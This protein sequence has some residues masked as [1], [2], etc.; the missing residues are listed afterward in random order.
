MEKELT[1]AFTGHR[2][3]SYRFHPD[4]AS[5][6]ILMTT[7]IGA[8][9]GNGV[10]TFLT[11][12]AAG[13]DIWGAELVLRFKKEYPDIRLIAVLPCESQADKWSVEL[14]ERY[15]NI[16]AECDETVYISRHYTKDCMFRRNR[17]LIDHAS[18]V[19]AIDNGSPRGG[20]A[21]T[22]NYA[23]QKHRAVITINPDT[24]SI[25]PYTIVIDERN[26]DAEKNS[27]NT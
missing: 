25:T 18:F 7:Q 6:K 4:C 5:I 3:S 11:G 21:Y 15:F 27:P 16:L 17:W 20:T 10:R 24:L 8:L 19:L 22:V 13:A 9:I 12:M 23:R 2:P 26:S 14:R 1:C